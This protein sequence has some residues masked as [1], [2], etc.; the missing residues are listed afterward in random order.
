MSENISNVFFTNNKE[1]SKNISKVSV[2][3]E[4]SVAA[5]GIILR[6]PT[7]YLNKV[8][9]ESILNPINNPLVVYIN[10]S[11]IF[12]KSGDFPHTPNLV[13]PLHPAVS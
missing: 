11:C 6:D 10:K 12:A 7:T 2:T 4:G 1:D 5:K 9:W 3:W 8:S 13:H